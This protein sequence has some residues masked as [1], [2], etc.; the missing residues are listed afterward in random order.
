MTRKRGRPAVEEVRCP[1]CRSVAWTRLGERVN[2]VGTKAGRTDLRHAFA[3]DSK[4]W[5]WTCERCGHSVRPGS[6][7]DNALSRVQPR[8]LPGILVGLLGSERI[9]GGGYRSLVRAAQ[10]TAVA[11]GGVVVVAAAAM[12]LGRAP[13]PSASPPPSVSAAEAACERAITNL[14]D[15]ARAGDTSLSECPVDLAEVQ[16]ESVTGDET[17][18]VQTSGG[19]VF[20]VLDEELQPEEA[21]TV[22]AGQTLRI[23]GTVRRTPPEAVE[24]TTADK[25]ALEKESLYVLAERVDI[26]GS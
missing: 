11:V 21:V 10:A 1:A 15:I 2:E 18:W 14:D 3:S 26:A 5:D 4:A 17:F 16:V 25:A 7:L 13:A 20:V 6:R 9:G 22:R 12:F 23:A 8:V 24:L 19:R